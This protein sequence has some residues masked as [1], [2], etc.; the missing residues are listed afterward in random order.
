M[1]SVLTVSYNCLPWLKLLVQSVRKHSR[2][3]SEIV[4][5]DNDSEDGTR[6]WLTQQPDIRAEH[7]SDNIGHGRGLDFGMGLVRTGQRV[8]VLDCDAHITR[9]GWDEELMWLYKKDSATHLI[10]AQGND[11]KPVHPCVMFFERDW[12]LDNHLSFVAR[13]GYDVGRKLYPDTLALGGKVEMLPVGYE[14]YGD[15][16]GIKFYAGAWGDT[17]YLNERPAFYHQWYSSRMYGVTDVD[18]YKREDHDANA[19]KIFDN[20][21]IKEIMAW[22]KPLETRRQSL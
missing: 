6:E 13:E 20:P 3:V 19:R 11:R 18:G 8:L 22:G 15:A 17:Y 4:V 12:F 7:R 5:V 10:A 14:G 21:R 9:P 2:L 16:A 1:I